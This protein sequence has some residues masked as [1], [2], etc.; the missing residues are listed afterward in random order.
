MGGAEPDMTISQLVSEG[1]GALDRASVPGAAYDA[2]HLALFLKKWTF[3]EYSLKRNEDV[4]EA[5]LSTYRELIEKRA[6][7]IPLQYIMGTAPFFGHDFYVTPDV[8]IPRFD[9]ENLVE[10][11]LS[12]L[13]QKRGEEQRVLD[14]C[15]GSGCVP[16]SIMLEGIEGVICTG[17]DVSERA[18]EV[19]RRNAEHFHVQV[20]FFK[21]DLFEEVDGEYAIITSNPPYIR[22]EEIAALDPEVRDH[23]PRLALDGG[24][25]GL[26]FYRKIFTEAPKHLME[27]GRLMMEIGADQ[28]KDVQMLALEAGFDECHFCKDLSGHDRVAIA[29]K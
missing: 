17:T 19:A 29:R 10:A 13:K 16:I 5:F 11:A 12:A 3:T 8:L 4:D 26:F 18:L 21:S 23:E 27:G 24:P 22:P 1:A 9:T 25:D 6:E 20:N 2:R 28:R 15:T 14:L 7:R